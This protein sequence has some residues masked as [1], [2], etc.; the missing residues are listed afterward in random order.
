MRPLIL[1]TNDDGIQARGIQH[2]MD[3]AQAFGDIVVMSPERNASGMS[4]SLT[5]QQ[6][7]R[8]HTLEQGEE[9]SVYTCSGTPVD[10]VKM[11]TEHFCRRRP[12][13]VLS[14]INHG[15]NASINVVYSGTMGAVIEGCLDGFQSIGFS[16]LSHN[17]EADFSGCTK[18][19]ETILAYVLE[20]PLPEWTGLNVNIPRLGAE[21][22]KG[23]RLCR[24][25]RARWT[26]SLTP[27]TDPLGR[28]YWWMT[29]KFENADPADDTD[30]YALEHGYVS[31]VPIRP[32]YTAEAAIPHLRKLEILYE[33]TT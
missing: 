30:L 11:G 8:V 14:G 7:L 17:P 32:D 6:P 20:H 3:I 28:P 13:L 16:L 22:I 4:S 27:R 19:I 33:E 9:R 15:S 29:G 5:T 31:V 25:A 26:D 24:S 2:L 23:I 18:S 21:E 1:I 12:S 10:C